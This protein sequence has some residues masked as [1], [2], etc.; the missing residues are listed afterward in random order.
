MRQQVLPW[1]MHK[2]WAQCLLGIGQQIQNFGAIPVHGRRATSD[3]F[4]LTAFLHVHA[5]VRRDCLRGSDLLRL[6]LIFHV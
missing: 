4:I 1:G 2:P 5:M 6:Q 3:P